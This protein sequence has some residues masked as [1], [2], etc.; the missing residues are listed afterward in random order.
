MFSLQ[1]LLVI[2]SHSIIVIVS[3]VGNILVFYISMRYRKRTNFNS[4]VTNLAVSDLVLTIFV[5]G[6]LHQ[7]IAG[8]WL[9]PEFVCSFNVY[10][11]MLGSVISPYIM[12]AIACERYSAIVN[13]LNTESFVR[14]Q[15]S[16]IIFM[17]WTTCGIYS[18]I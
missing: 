7:T 6:R 4:L 5:T 9:L 16:K 18:L 17:I 12:F 15:K 1:T 2:I 8:N 11:G 3:L 10:L 14:C 13:P